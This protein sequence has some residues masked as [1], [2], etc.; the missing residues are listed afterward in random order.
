MKK[1]YAFALA[2]M[3]VVSMNAQDKIYLAGPADV[4]INGE[5]FAAA[6]APAQ[7]MELTAVDGKFTF[8]AGNFGSFKISTTPVAAD[9]PAGEEWNVFNAGAM[10]ANFPKE[11]ESGNTVDMFQGDANLMAPW[12][13]DWDIVITTGE[14]WTI[15]MTTETPKPTGYT[16]V[17]LRGNDPIG[18]NAPFK[19]EYTF[20][21]PDGEY[22]FLDITAENAL[23][24]G[25]NFKIADGS[26]GAINYGLP[27]VNDSGVEVFPGSEETFIYDAADVI[28]GDE[29][30]NGTIVLYLPE[31][32]KGDAKVKF[33]EEIIEHTAVAGIEAIEAVDTVEGAAEY[34]NLQGVRVN[35]PAAGLYLV[36]K[37][38]KVSKVV[39]K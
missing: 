3:A 36:R 34:Y 12:V 23:A 13:G 30:N 1:I 20:D 24:A 8:K 10:S 11:F 15:T 9:T 22:Y 16:P 25:Q 21:T 28:M 17:Y 5:N 31:T 4:T 19:A 32:A 6:W 29:Y 2:A 26:W 7:A 39:V 35:E 33:L 27:K 18:W 38:G 14:T 37:A